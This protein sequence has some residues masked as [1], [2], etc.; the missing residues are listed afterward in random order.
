M[1]SSILQ[2]KGEDE[3]IS[4]RIP[5][6]QKSSAQLDPSWESSHKI[7]EV[8]NPGAYQLAHLNGDR[9]LRLWNADYLRMYY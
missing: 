8:L 2:L 6:P 4:R 9:I 1:H 5:R 7:A 3:K